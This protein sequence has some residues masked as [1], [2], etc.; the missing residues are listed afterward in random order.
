MASISR[1]LALRTLSSSVD[2]T[3]A[4]F[5]SISARMAAISALYF[6]R[7]STLPTHA[8]MGAAMAVASTGSMMVKSSLLI[9]YSGLFLYS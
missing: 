5:W 2:F 7:C 9:V 8:P 4:S 1:S 6:C 3:P